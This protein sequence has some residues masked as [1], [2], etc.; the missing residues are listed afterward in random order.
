[1]SIILEEGNQ[2]FTKKGSV[3]SF[4]KM[5]SFSVKADLITLC[6]KAVKLNN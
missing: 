1:M 2:E 5:V 4:I 6:N 3:I